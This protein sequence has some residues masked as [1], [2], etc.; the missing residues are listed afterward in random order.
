MTLE[1]LL[2]LQNTPR[3]NPEPDIDEI[4]EEEWE[5][6]RANLKMLVIY[7]LTNDKAIAP[8]EGNDRPS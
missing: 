1:E 8:K 4:T 2:E 3:P 6:A 5:E 7:S